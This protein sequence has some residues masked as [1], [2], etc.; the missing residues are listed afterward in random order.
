MWMKPS[1]TCMQPNKN[2]CK[3]VSHETGILVND[4]TRDADDHISSTFAGVSSRVMSSA[5]IAAFGNLT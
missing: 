2:N 5:L 3:D 4:T 1:H